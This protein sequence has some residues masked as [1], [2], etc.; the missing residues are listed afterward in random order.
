MPI[1]LLVIILLAVALDGY[2]PLQVKSVLYALSLTIKSAIVFVLP[3]LVFMLLFRAVSKLASSA[4]WMIACILAAVVCSNFVSIMISQMIGRSVYHLGLEIALPPDAV[5]LAPAWTLIFPKLIPNN[6]AM[7]GGILLGLLG[8]RFAPGLTNRISGFFDQGIHLMLQ[9]IVRVIPLFVAGFA[10]KLMHDNL[11]QSM[12]HHYS[13]IFLVVAVSQISYIC[14]LFLAVN[15]FKLRGFI[16]CMKNLVP[17]AVAG[18]GSMS[19]AATLPLTLIAAEKNTQNPTLVRLVIPTTVNIHLMGCCFAIPILAFAVMRSFGFPEPTYPEYMVF[20]MYFLIAKFSA[21][22]IPGGGILIMLPILESQFG[23]N[24]Q[25]AALIS[26]L[27]ILLDPITTCTNI[28]GNSALAQI[29]N[30]MTQQSP[31]PEVVEETPA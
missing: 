22:G 10:V 12:A 28:L 24:S 4:T 19:S 29:V 6:L 7:F 26:A 14:F 21:A 8:S 17:P 15:N 20:A 1:V 9:A 27:Y 3:V 23:F 11:L 5:S 16:R 30:R 31:K 2:L 18:F 13:F 25:M